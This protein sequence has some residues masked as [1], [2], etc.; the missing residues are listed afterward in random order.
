[1]GGVKGVSG[2]QHPLVDR[3]AKKKGVRVFSS[4]RNLRVQVADKKR[5]KFDEKITRTCH[6]FN[7]RCNG[8]FLIICQKGYKYMLYN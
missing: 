3:Q 5:F 7:S 8:L 1:M 2:R 4:H 6:L